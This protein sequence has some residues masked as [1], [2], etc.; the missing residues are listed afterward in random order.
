MSRVD[1]S[2][3]LLVPPTRR[4]GEA[5]S[6]LLDTS[7]VDCKVCRSMSELCAEMKVGVGSVLVAEESLTANPEEFINGIRGQSVWSDIAVIV[8]SRSGTELPQLT[9][10]IPYLG[11]VSVVERPVRVNTLLAMVRSSLRARQRQYEVREHIAQQLDAEAELR[12]SEERLHMA[13]QTGRLGVWEIDLSRHALTCSD[14]CRANYGRKPGETFTYNDLWSAV[15]TE[16]VDRVLA[17]LQQSARTGVEFELEYRTVWPDLTEHWMLARGRPGFDASHDSPRL[18]GVTL[19]ITDRKLAEEQRASLLAAEREARGEAERAGRMKDEFLTT[20][21]HEL[22]TPLNAILG[23]SQVLLLQRPNEKELQDGLHT[24]ERNARAQTQIIEDLL[25]MSRI[26]SGKV[27]LDMHNTDVAAVVASAVET[28]KPAAEAKGV[29]LET[30]LDHTVGV[31]SGDAG[32]LQQ[33][34][35]NLLNNA[36]KFTPRGE[37]VSVTLKSAITGIEIYVQ[38]TGDGIGADFLPHMFDRFRQADASTTRRHGGLGLGLAIVKQL[39]ELHGGTVRAYSP[40]KGRGATFIV[41]L[42]LASG[43]GDH[44]AEPAKA[45]TRVSFSAD[46]VEWRTDLSGCRILAVDDE[47]DSL[48]LLKRLLEDCHASVLVASSADEAFTLLQTARPD[49]LISDI[50]MPVQDGFAL[51]RRIRLLAVEQ[52]GQTPAIALTAYAR[53]EDRANTAHAGFQ[54]HIAKPLDPPQLIAA[55]ADLVRVSGYVQE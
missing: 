35:W 8:L 31:V 55:V 53:S 13:V 46:H 10:L 37:R 43:V 39:I 24:I 42:P 15:H 1:E 38:D 34:F 23:W 17:H 18:V 52:G 21:S 9:A 33:V 40:G 20:L 19:D 45:T 28:V 12:S 3:V 50:G 14:G 54:H 16:D 41:T 30:N 49:V 44:D 7:R 11:N 22:R 27:R 2:R 26:V 4:D 5:I 6:K 32:R 47:P 36:V 51:I 25:D 29:L 48:S